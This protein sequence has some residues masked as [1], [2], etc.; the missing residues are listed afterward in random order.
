MRLHQPTQDFILFFS[1]LFWFLCPCKSQLQTKNDD[2]A[3]YVTHI[4]AWITTNIMLFKFCT[5]FNPFSLHH[6]FISFLQLCCYLKIKISFLVSALSLWTKGFL[7]KKRAAVIRLRQMYLRK[8][9]EQQHPI[10][11]FTA[12][13]KS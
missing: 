1:V 3:F 11:F 8:S 12:V 7:W 6:I 4:T 10:L 9:A 5:I 2:T 13:I